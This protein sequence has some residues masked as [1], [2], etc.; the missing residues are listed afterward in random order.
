[1]WFAINVSHCQVIVQVWG[2]ERGPRIGE[3]S[4][5]IDEVIKEYGNLFEYVTNEI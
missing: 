1:M 4:H 5:M 3:S 2:I